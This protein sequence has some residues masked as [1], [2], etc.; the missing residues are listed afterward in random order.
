MSLREE[1]RDIQEGLGEYCRTGEEP[2]LPGI[3][4]GRIHHYHRLVQNVVKDTLDTA[5]P[6]T[7][8]AL[9]EDTWNLLV[10]D[11]FSSGLPQTPQVW[12]LPYEF[13][14]YHAMQES[15]KRIQ[16]EYLDDLLLF[17]WMEI[18][19]HTMPDREYPEYVE[20]GNLF[21][22]R[23][24]FNPEYEIV[25]LNFPIHTH[26]V[27]E[28][29]DMKGDY[30]ALLYRL[31]ESGNVQFLALSPLNTF[32]FSRLREAELPLNVIKGEFAQLAGI[33]SG[34]YLDEAL[35]RF[36]QDLIDRKLIL[37]FLKQ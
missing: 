32:I 15:G 18:E 23:L 33:E 16:R 25:Q 11:F 35:E 29:R 2:N 37:G 36:F 1:T 24:A 8:T 14:H 19:V 27:T 9:G 26:P 28:A 20:K 22:D 7:L 3:T 5:Y 34:R 17:E 12:K 13:Y 30:F 31:P 4:P 6:I 10:K 21:L